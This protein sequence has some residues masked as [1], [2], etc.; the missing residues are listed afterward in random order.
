MCEVLPALGANNVYRRAYV[1]VWNNSL[2]KINMFV[3]IPQ[4][5]YTING[6]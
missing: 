4:Y 2:I 1:I 5:Y 6:K 3:E